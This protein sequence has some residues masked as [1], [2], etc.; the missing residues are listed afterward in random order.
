[1]ATDEEPK[2]DLEEA[3]VSSGQTAVEVLLIFVLF[4]VLAGGVPPD[5]NEA[6]YLAKAKHYWNPQWCR[7]DFFLESADAH[8]VFYWTLGWLTQFL[9]LSATAWI[10]RCLTW[11]LLA[12]AWQRLSVSILPARLSSLL[13]AALFAMLLR[14]GHMAGEW[15][16]GGVEAKGFAYV[17]V[18]LGLEALVRTRWNAV[19]VFFGAAAAFHV[20]VGGWAVIAG[21]IAWC[22]SSKQRPAFKSMLPWLVAGGLTS[23]FG[24]VPGIVLA[25]GS[26]AATVRDANEVYAWRLGH[27]LSFSHILTQ[28]ITIDFDYLGVPAVASSIS[29]LYFLRHVALFLVAVG[30]FFFVKPKQP[31]R[32]LYCFCLGAIIIATAGIVIDQATFSHPDMA[33]KLLRYYWFRLSDVMLPLAT[34]FL[35]AQAIERQRIEGPGLAAAA[36][37]ASVVLVTLNVADVYLRRAYDPTP[38]AIVRAK[39]GETNDRQQQ[40][41][42]WRNT[43]EW[44]REE[45]PQDAVFLTPQNQQTFKWYA[46]R[47]EVVCWKDVPQNANALVEWRDRLA[48]VFPRPV[49]WYGLAAHTPENLLELSGRYNF[50]Y[51]V[52]DRTLS[53]RGLP[54]RRVYPT[55][56]QLDS[57]YEVYR[58]PTAAPPSLKDERG[59]DG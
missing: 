24:L 47:A 31:A 34:A 23:L 48:A 11:L 14:S 59:G 55:R 13:T 20:L 35:I 25:I 54:F 42:D 12:W 28:P 39:L 52:I 57:V 45:T 26:D 22:I 58:L 33:A 50:R 30:S 37:S 51:V 53:Q 15:V 7:G 36:L 43:C 27:H 46:E 17:L 8:I 41:R 10:G 32:H 38:I 3:R 4:F 56:S 40:Y 9:S 18:L 6:H 2:D 44:I 29:H 1:M 19:W 16:I 5:V 49:R 21:L